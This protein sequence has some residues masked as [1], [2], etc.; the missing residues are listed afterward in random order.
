[1]GGLSFE[2]LVEAATNIQ[3]SINT[4]TG[5]LWAVEIRGGIDDSKGKRFARAWQ[6]RGK[7]YASPMHACREFLA[8]WRQNY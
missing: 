5:S 6:E 4:E 7:K 2:S 8:F 3:V 1:M